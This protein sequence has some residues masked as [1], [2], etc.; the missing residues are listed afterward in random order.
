MYQRPQQLMS[1]LSRDFKIAYIN[2][3]KISDTPVTKEADLDWYCRTINPNLMVFTPPRPRD[4]TPGPGV[5]TYFIDLM[6]KF[7]EQYGFH[8]S[9]LWLNMPETV[10]FCGELNEKLVIYDCLDDY[11][12]FSWTPKYTSEA[13]AALTERADIVFVVSD[14]L[15]NLKYNSC[16]SCYL[17][18]NACDFIHF[19]RAF[20]SNLKIP[21]AFENIGNP[22]IGFVG[23][24]YE[25][26]D[27]EL[28]SYLA[29]RNKDWSIVLV[30]PKHYNVN[31][32]SLPNVYYL[33]KKRYRHL[34][35]YQRSMANYARLLV[36]P[37]PEA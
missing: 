25:W 12:S 2:P 6:K 16:R 3:P 35:R 17:I 13:D 34:P 37:K 31:K 29:K 10:Y 28:L 11:G 19:N 5:R 1:L 14:Y 36:E 32:I 33:G 23:A 30:G 27:Y 9:I 4:L 15:H 21:E 24:L 26:V 18:P 20:R 8:D 7:I 22:R